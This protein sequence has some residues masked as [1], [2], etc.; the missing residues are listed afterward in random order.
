MMRAAF[1]TAIAA[2]LVAAPAR[3]DAQKTPIAIENATVI[4]E[5]GKTIENA[6]VIIRNG[7]ITAVGKDVTVP[8]GA[9]RIDGKDKIVT[10]G[11]IEAS[12]RVGLVEVD[13]VGATNEGR[14]KD[15]K[16]ADAV[17][18]AY[19]VSDGYNASSVAI[20]IARTGGVT[21][22]VAVPSGGLVSGTSAAYSMSDGNADDVLLA[23]EVAMY[24]ALG[25]SALGSSEGSRGVALENLRELF[26]DA[27]DYARRKSSY[28][29]NQTRD[30]AAQRL[31]LAALGVVLRR[32]M[33]L[34]LQAHRSSD[35]LAALRLAK[36]LNIRI[37]IE[38]GVEAWTVAD[39]LA[40]AKV[41]VIVDP[42]S[43]LPSSFDR[44]HVV[45]DAARRLADKGVQVVISTSREAANVRTL[46]QLAGN[47]VANG[48]AWDDALAA[49][50][51]SPAA[52]L[53][54]DKRGTLNK[55]S[56][57]DV[58]VWTG[59]PF[60]LSSGP[61]LVLIKGEKQSLRT[62]QSKLLDRYRKLP[63]KAEPR[64]GDRR[65]DLRDR[66]GDPGLHWT[67]PATRWMPMSRWWRARSIPPPGLQDAGVRTS[68]RRR[69][70]P[71]VAS[72][73][74]IGAIL[75]EGASETAPEQSA[76][77]RSEP[78]TNPRL[79]NADLD[80]DLRCRR[81][82]LAERERVDH[83]RVGA[84]QTPVDDVALDQVQA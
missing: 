71:R 33:P 15:A 60:E 56:V 84:L 67:G 36:D 11:F 25:E 55:G 26:D 23:D 44:I 1:I 66:A 9:E 47:A 22:A 17:H 6:T 39:K 53:G 72:L 77:N 31:D 58:V 49:V 76:Q 2:A 75:F 28:D 69:L 30:Y 38:G 27:R 79:G 80:H 43:N 63:K 42:L 16:D 52:V 74:E 82:D 14:F 68:S 24:A 46:R 59:D 54:L 20:P 73:L 64:A 18:A 13:Q 35:I 40:A 7:V 61:S 5:P 32:Q 57:A 19:R 81:P 21:T 12:S 34:V 4:V 45:D 48:L 10:A 41:P 78:S 65:I 62:R 29:R 37:V 70:W 83:S 8:S 3:A 51:T 50:T